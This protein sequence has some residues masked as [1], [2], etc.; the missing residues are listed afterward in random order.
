MKD[1]PSATAIFLKRDS[2]FILNDLIGNGY[3]TKVSKQSY[4]KVMILLFYNDL[5]L[6]PLAFLIPSLIRSKYLRR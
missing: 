4:R 2:V 6:Q 5:T 3:H 1:I